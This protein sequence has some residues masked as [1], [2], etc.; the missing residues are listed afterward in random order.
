MVFRK[1]NTTKKSLKTNLLFLNNVTKIAWSDKL[2]YVNWSTTWF[3]LMCL[4]FADYGCMLEILTLELLPDGRSYVDTVGGSRFRVLKR[5]Q[6]DG[7]HTADI[8]Y[9]EDLKVRVTE[10]TNYWYTLKILQPPPDSLLLMTLRL[11]SP[12]F[13]RL[14]VLRWSFCSISMTVCTSRLRTG[15]SVSAAAFASRSTDSTAPCQIRR[16]TFR[17]GPWEKCFLV[18]KCH[19]N[20]LQSRTVIIYLVY[21][22]LRI[23]YAKHFCKPKPTIVF[24]FIKM[25]ISMHASF[26]YGYQLGMKITLQRFQTS[27]WQNCFV[28]EF[29]YC[30]MLLQCR[31]FQSNRTVS[32]IT[33]LW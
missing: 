11:S 20:T 19:N 13:P 18:L 9:L 26:I 33:A 31:F 17:L 24:D 12:L 23:M 1:G 14:M 21:F 16:K 28:F 8:E 32:S 15:T 6:R 2:S 27:F 10:I 3:C 29:S 30:F 7:Y 4:R 5:G 22:F 25:Y